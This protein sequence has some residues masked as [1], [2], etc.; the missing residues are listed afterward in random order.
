ML[1]E[2]LPMRQRPWHDRPERGKGPLR[3]GRA[4]VR[5]VDGRDQ[6]RQRVELTKERLLTVLTHAAERT[7]QTQ[8]DR[9]HVLTQRRYHGNKG[10]E[11]LYN[12]ARLKKS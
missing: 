3:G 6:H 9:E 11:S 2:V 12:K 8:E 5:L 10:I 4:D 1:T 7:H